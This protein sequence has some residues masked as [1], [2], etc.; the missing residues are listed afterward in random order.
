MAVI[1]PTLIGVL[2][3]FGKF[4]CKIKLFRISRKP[5]EPF[6]RWSYVTDGRAGGPSPHFF[7]P[8]VTDSMEQSP[9][10]EANR[11]QLVKKFPKF[12]GTRRFITAFTRAHHPS[13]FGANYIQS[14]PSYPTSYKSILILSFHL[15]LGSCQWS[16]FSQILT[17]NFCTHLSSIPY[18]LRTPPVSFLLDLIIWTI[19]G[20]KFYF[21]EN[22]W[23]VKYVI[24]CVCVGVSELTSWVLL[25][26]LGSLFLLRKRKLFMHKKCM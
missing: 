17:P 13:L 25:L 24:L 18:V 16:L 9:S 12:Y 3:L 1:V 10:W 2:G 21:A 6:G 23:S 15:R 26:L 22:A 20:E 4:M 11:F 5:N 8:Q 14:M 7:F 19:F